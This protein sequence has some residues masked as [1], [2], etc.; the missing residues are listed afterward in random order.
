MTTDTTL[1]LREARLRIGSDGVAEF[2]HQRPEARNALSMAMREDYQDLLA[3]VENDR[4]IRALVIT[5][6]G[7]SFCA[8]GDVKGMAHMHA[9]GSEDAGLAAQARSR[10]A[11]DQHRWLDRLRSLDV[12]VIAAVDGPAF[13]A[14]ASLALMADFVLTSTRASFCMVFARMGMVPDF[15]AFH[16]LPRLVGLAKAKELMM[17]ARRVDAHEAAALGIAYAVHEPQQ[18]LEEAHRLAARLA[19]GPRDA[20]GMIKNSLNRSFENDYRTMAEIEAHQQAVAMSL[21]YHTDAVQRFIRKQPLAYDWDRVG[22]PTRRE[23]LQ[24]H[25]SAP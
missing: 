12:P 7:G 22:E 11:A 5:G 17:T 16:T 4:S 21:P 14:G 2:S 10:I 1:E 18:L 15:G 20:L 9:S 8:G 3:R 24:P 13:G 6:S 19:S 23:A 25:P